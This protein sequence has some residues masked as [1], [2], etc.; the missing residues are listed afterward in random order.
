MGTSLMSTLH[1]SL[2]IAFLAVSIV[3]SGPNVD[4]VGAQE[5]VVGTKASRRP[6]DLTLS[7][8]LKFRRLTTEDGL[9][10]NQAFGVVQDKHGFMWFGTLNGLSRYDGTSVKVYR[11]NPD[12]PDSLGHNT[13]RAWNS[14]I[15]AR[16]R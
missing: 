14:K 9:V 3:I 1:K 8:Y 11:H 5:S 6:V 16:V 4:P 13:V 10:G 2:T 7:P 12:D 15:Y